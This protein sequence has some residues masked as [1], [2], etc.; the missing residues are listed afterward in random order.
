MITLDSTDGDVDGVILTLRDVISGCGTGICSLIFD[1]TRKDTG[2]MLRVPA[3]GTI[4]FLSH[5]GSHNFPK[6]EKVAEQLIDLNI[7]SSV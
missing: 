7:A 1:F 4:L 3:T 5:F 6:E 2:K